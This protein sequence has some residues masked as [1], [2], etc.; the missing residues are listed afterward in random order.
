M[1]LIQNHATCYNRGNPPQWLQNPKLV[2]AI[3]LASVYILNA[4]T[5][6]V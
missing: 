5:K 6:I 4:Y 3:A 1:V 2:E